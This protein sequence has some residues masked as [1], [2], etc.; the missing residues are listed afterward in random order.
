MGDTVIIKKPSTKGEGFDSLSMRTL[1]ADIH[2]PPANK[3]MA[4]ARKFGI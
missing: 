4:H 3:G 1:V 2:Q